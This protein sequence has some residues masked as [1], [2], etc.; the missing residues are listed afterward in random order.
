MISW[1]EQKAAVSGQACMPAW[2]GRDGVLIL[3]AF[4]NIVVDFWVN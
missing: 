2:L 1:P 4:S 3:T